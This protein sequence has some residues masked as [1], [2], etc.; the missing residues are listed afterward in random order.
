MSMRYL[1][2][3]KGGMP[4][5]L[6]V[7]VIVLY[8]LLIIIFSRKGSVKRLGSLRISETELTIFSGFPYNYRIDE[9]ERVTFSYTIGKKNA[10]IGVMRVWKTESNEKGTPFLYDSGCCRK[11]HGFIDT[12]QD[13]DEATQYLIN[14]LKKH[15]IKCERLGREYE[16]LI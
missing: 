4:V 11:R 16:K 9:I 5:M 1:N 3:S 7:G 6:M 8:V 10:F 2:L 12:K 13:I 15:R 14:K